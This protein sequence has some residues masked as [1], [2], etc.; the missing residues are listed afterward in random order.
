[1]TRMTKT[2]GFIVAAALTAP[3]AARAD[4]GE[5]PDAYS[6]GWREDRLSSGIGVATVLGGGVTGF[7][8]KTLRDTTTNNLNGLWDL[9]LTIGSHIPLGIDLGYVGT[10][11][12]IDALIGTRSATLIGT[13]VEGA[14]RWNVLPHSTINPYLFGGIGWQRY[15]VTGATFRQ[16][17]TGLR[18]SDNSVVFPLGAGLS[19][20][21]SDGLVLDLR[22]TF[23]ASTQGKLV[24]DSPDSTSF[25][26]QHTWEASGGLGYE[27]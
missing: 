9:R 17:A 24:L 12:N 18:D 22:G 2:L 11:A 19:Y 14:L 4:D 8:D 13:T 15:D 20:R 21:S 1:M 6:Y 25:A 7:T 5:H 10:A 23:R 16:A 26:P 27:F 3:S